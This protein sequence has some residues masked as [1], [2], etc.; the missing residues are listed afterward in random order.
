MGADIVTWR[1]TSDGAHGCTVPCVL[2]RKAIEALGLRVTCLVQ[3]GE[4]FR[5]RLTEPD[6]PRSKLTSG[7]VRVF[8]SRRE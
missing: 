5:G 7:Q 1:I 3:D 4:W 8:K 2:C 6:A